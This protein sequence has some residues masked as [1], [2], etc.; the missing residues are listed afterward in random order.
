M[1]TVWRL[2]ELLTSL[3]VELLESLNDNKK[4]IIT[5]LCFSLFSFQS[6]PSKMYLFPGD[7]FRFPAKLNTKPG[8]FISVIPKNY[9][10]KTTPLQLKCVIILNKKPLISTHAIDSSEKSRFAFKTNDT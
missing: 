2:F 5:Y 10:Y 6:N 1:T 8:S 9:Q 3:F 7:I 4:S